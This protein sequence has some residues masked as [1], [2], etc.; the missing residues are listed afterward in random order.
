MN[1]LCELTMELKD[2]KQSKNWDVDKFFIAAHSFKFSRKLIK[3][4]FFKFIV[5][6]LEIR[7]G[8]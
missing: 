2:F 8:V 3:V 1:E 4:L 7:K 6:N 5:S